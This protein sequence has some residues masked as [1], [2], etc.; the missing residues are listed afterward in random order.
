MDSDSL[1]F[2]SFP[3]PFLND[4]ILHEDLTCG[5]AGSE[6]G[7]GAPSGSSSSLSSPPPAAGGLDG[8]GSGPLE[9]RRRRR[10][11]EPERG[12]SRGHGGP[13]LAAAGGQPRGERAADLGLGP[14]GA[15]GSGP[16]RGGL[17]LNRVLCSLA[18]HQPGECGVGRSGPR[19][20]A[21]LH[22]CAPRGSGVR[23]LRAPLAVFLG[24]GRSGVR[25]PPT[26][27]LPPAASAPPRVPVPR[28]DVSGG[29]R[30][31]RFEGRLP[32]APIPLPSK[33]W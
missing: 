13:A 2:G 7:A 3:I 9:R 30:G 4:C 27:L 5:S 15:E 23:S 31:P 20:P 19:T 25:V 11:S 17:S 28:D 16:A 18:G 22:L 6:K 21:R 10:R 1:S 26:W 12:R 24:A 14:R 8:P 32:C 29:F 33:C